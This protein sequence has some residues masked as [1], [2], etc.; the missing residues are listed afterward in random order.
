MTTDIVISE[1]VKGMSLD[2]YQIQSKETAVYVGKGEWMGLAYCILGLTG[3]AGEVANDVKK[4]NRDDRTTR[5]PE[6]V[7]RVMDE[8]GDLLWYFVATCTELG[9]SAQTI[10]EMN[11][12]KLKS[13]QTRG[14]LHG[15]GSKR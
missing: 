4:M 8:L 5:K 15:D 13:R 1:E 12:E 3:E 7:E 10:M 2:E 9:V 6:R 11:R 14:V